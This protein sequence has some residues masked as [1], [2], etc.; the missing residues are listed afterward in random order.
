MTDNALPEHINERLSLLKDK[1]AGRRLT[2]QHAEEMAD[3]IYGLMLDAVLYSRI[4]EIIK[5]V[6]PRQTVR[7]GASFN[8][9][10]PRIDLDHDQS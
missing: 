9:S 4:D 3:E 6:F 1:W 7:R 2:K 10:L 5:K 8:G